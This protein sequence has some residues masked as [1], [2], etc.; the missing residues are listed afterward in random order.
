M[1]RWCI[2]AAAETE[3]FRG[4]DQRSGDK[5]DDAESVKTVHEC[6]QM[7]VSL[8]LAEIVSVCCALSVDRRGAM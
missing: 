8:Q 1:S 2:L 3:V 5:C 4:E 7:G 6:E